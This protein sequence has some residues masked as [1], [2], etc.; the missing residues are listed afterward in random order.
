[1][2]AAVGKKKKVPIEQLSH[3]FNCAFLK[4]QEFILK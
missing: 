3:Y 4:S 2:I 1:M